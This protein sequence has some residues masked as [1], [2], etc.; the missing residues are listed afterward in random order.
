[1]VYARQFQF[2]LDYTAIDSIRVED[3]PR[4]NEI[5]HR[6]AR[7]MDP[8]YGTLS[9]AAFR[10]PARCRLKYMNPCGYLAYIRN[11]AAAWVASYN[12]AL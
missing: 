6:W 9:V 10:I 11:V 7:K 1:M 4:P 5:T 2:Y 8:I 12:T 3:T